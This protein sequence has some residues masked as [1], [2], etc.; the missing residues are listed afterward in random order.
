MVREMGRKIPSDRETLGQRVGRIHSL[1]R[2]LTWKSEQLFAP[3][4]QR[5]S[6]NARYAYAV[7]ARG[8]F[9][10]EQAAIKCLYLVTRSPGPTGKGRVR[11]AARPKPARGAFAITFA[12]RFPAAEKY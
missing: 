12:D 6:V 8:H 4:E 3:R 10:T 11:W 9:P 7:K 5:E 1:A 2:L